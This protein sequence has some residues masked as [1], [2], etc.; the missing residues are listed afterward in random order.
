MASM[1]TRAEVYPARVA[2]VP[3]PAIV[4][5]VARMTTHGRFLAGV[6][7]ETVSEGIVF[8]PAGNAAPPLGGADDQVVMVV[9]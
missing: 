5:P 2:D 9:S 4:P 3:V 6:P 7:E 1:E 8:L